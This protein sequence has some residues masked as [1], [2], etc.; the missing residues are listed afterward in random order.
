[1]WVVGSK[2]CKYKLV[3][4]CKAECHLSGVIFVSDALITQCRYSIVLQ[5]HTHIS[6]KLHDHYIN[7]HLYIKIYPLTFREYSIKLHLFNS[8]WM[9]IRD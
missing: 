8:Y 5:K 3:N 1:M 7:T 9:K 6:L 4:N 2:E